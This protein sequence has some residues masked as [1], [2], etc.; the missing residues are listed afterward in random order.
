MKFYIKVFLI[1]FVGFLA[2]F[3]G[4]LFAIDAIISHDDLPEIAEEETT[5]TTEVGGIDDEGEFGGDDNRTEL[6]KIADASSRINIIAFGLN[7]HLADTMML[8]SYDP[9]LNKIDIMSIPRDTYNHIEG[10]ND[11]AQKKMNA[12]Y[13]FPE[14]GGVNGMKRV[15]S[16]F[17]GI[18]IHYYLK[19]DFE[20]VEAVVNTLGGYEVTVPFDMDYDD[21]YDTPPLRIHLKKGY[22][23][24]NGEDSVRYLRFRKNSDGSRSEGDIQRIPRQQHFVSTMMKKALSSKLPSVINTIIGGE[25]VTTDM[26]LEKALSLAIKGASLE[27]E[28]IKFYT[29]EGEARMISGS[30]YWI[31]DPASLEKTLYSFYGF[32]TDTEEAGGST[33][34][35]SNQTTEGSTGN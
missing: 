2:L 34:D 27:S 15:L 8:F 10:F 11:L 32:T 19:V 25:Y 12:V 13:G 30:S 4:I 21:F 35:A 33:D 14:V 22:Q 26:T 29:L 31:H 17:L 6:Q 24:L 1:S 23:V 3:T 7:D 20:A 9:E 16:E 5:E 28:S 18:P